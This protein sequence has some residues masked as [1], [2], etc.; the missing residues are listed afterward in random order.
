M[1]VGLMI[2]VVGGVLV[3]AFAALA[4]AY[5]AVYVTPNLMRAIRTT[6][7]IPRGVQTTTPPQS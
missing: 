2:A 3:I 6:L 5:G 7:R 4:F 1:T